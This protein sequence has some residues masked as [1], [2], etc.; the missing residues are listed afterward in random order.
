MQY[1]FHTPDP[2]DLYVE[3]GAGTLD[4]RCEDVTETTVDVDGQNAEEVLVEQRGEQIVILAKQRGIG[5]FT[6]SDDLRV[7]V[8]MPGSSRLA[9]KL[10]SADVTVSGRVGEAMLKSG[11]GE[12]R[13]AEVDGN[14]LVETGSGNIE[15]DTVR[16]QLRAKSGSGD[17][18]LGH[19]GDVATVSTGS[20]DVRIETAERAVQMKSG[21]GDLRIRD[22]SEDVALSTA[23][24]EVQVDRM[25]RGQLAAK[26][27]SGDIRVGIPA[28]VPVWTDIST[29]TGSVR[30]GLQGAGKP[31]QGQDYVELRAKTV[32]GDVV[33]QQL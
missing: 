23:S 2:A 26:N 16:G 11:S 21:S 13:L 22:A 30:S 15:I 25:R 10:G 28:G 7:A 31:E 29:V 20:G 27:V 18:E 8:T 14:A 3:L 17:I 4:I 12:V 5:F 6:R 32:S 24:G 9:T 1:T 19:L 33:L